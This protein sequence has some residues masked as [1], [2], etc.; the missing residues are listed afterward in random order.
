MGV[1]CLPR[2]ASFNEI[3]ELPRHALRELLAT[4][5]PI[6]PEALVDF[7]Y[8]GTSLGLPAF[9]ERLTWKTFQ[10]VF[11]RE[12][13]TGLL[14]GWNVRVEQRGIGMPSQPR[15]RRG[16]PH[17]FGHFAVV[18]LDPA[19]AHRCSAGLLLD[20]G[21]GGNGTLDPLRWVR[22]PIVALSRDSADLLLGWTYLQLGA[23]RLSTPSY[24]VLERERPLTH[25][26]PPPRG[27]SRRTPRG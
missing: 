18:P 2:M 23:L 8:R 25:R 12:P 16:Q 14:R 24:F 9:V 13:D 7:E 22:D 6:S 3:L 26:A 17:T 19:M 11:C 15:L 10:K 27:A 21:Q 4:G 20:Y 5:H 1:L